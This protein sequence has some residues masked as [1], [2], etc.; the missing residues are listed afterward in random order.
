MRVGIV[1]T[2][3]KTLA[4]LHHFTKRG[5]GRSLNKLTTATFYWS[6]YTKP[7]MYAVM[8]MCIGCTDPASLSFS[9]ILLLDF[10]IVL[11][12]QFFLIWLCLYSRDRMVVGVTTTGL[13]NH[14]LSP[15]KLWVRIPFMARCT[16]YNIMW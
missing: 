2:C 5:R 1:F 9:T 13:C 8:Y 10:I 4:C 12:M 7:L 3:G 15:L 11:T 14:W 16:Q 6:A